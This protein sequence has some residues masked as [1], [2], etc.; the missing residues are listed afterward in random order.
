MKVSVLV[1]RWPVLALAGVCLLTLM[2][3][4]FSPTRPFWR[5]VSFDL[6]LCN[7]GFPNAKSAL[8]QPPKCSVVGEQAAGDGHTLACNHSAVDIALVVPFI[9][10]QAE[11][12]ERNIRLWA[13]PNYFPCDPHSPYHK[14]VDLVFQLTNDFEDFPDIKKRLEEALRLSDVSSCFH[15]VRYLSMRLTKE[16]DQYSATWFPPWAPAYSPGPSTMFHSIFGMEYFVNHYSHF[17]MMEPDVRAIRPGWVDQMYLEVFMDGSDFWQKGSVRYYTPQGDH[18]LNGNAFYKLGD[19]QFNCFLQQ[20]VDAK[21][22]RAFDVSMFEIASESK[23]RKHLHRLTKTVFVKNVQWN[24]SMPEFARKNP[25]TFL[26]HGSESSRRMEKMHA[27]YLKSFDSK[28]QPIY[29]GNDKGFILGG[30]DTE[31]LS[32]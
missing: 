30:E 11:K 24:F 16:Q 31:T 6:P 17:F 4:T 2:A 25:G 3:L 8:L 20:A 32:R 7:K 27:D 21:F 5:R 13:L 18:H 9:P 22:P 23:N 15:A 10:R 28:K 19:P 14:H 26:V 12:L 1:R 29:P